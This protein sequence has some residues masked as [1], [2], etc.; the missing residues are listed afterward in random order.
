MQCWTGHRHRRRHIGDRRSGCAGCRRQPREQ[1][2]RNPA[3]CWTGSA[4]GSLEVGTQQGSEDGTPGPPR[5]HH[6]GG[7]GSGG[8]GHLARDDDW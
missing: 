6:G 4:G 5:P 2:G 1:M 8:A 7:G 3:G